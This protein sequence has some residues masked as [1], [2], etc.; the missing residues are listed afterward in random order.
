MRDVVMPPSLLRDHPYEPVRFACHKCSR[1]GQYRK[2]ALVERYGPDE[3]MTNLRLN[4]G[5]RLPAAD[6]EQAPRSLRDLLSGP[7]GSVSARG[8]RA[9][10]FAWTGTAHHSAAKPPR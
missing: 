8:D 2:A 6:R 4:G 3:D 7:H 9:M 5:G 1:A 10:D